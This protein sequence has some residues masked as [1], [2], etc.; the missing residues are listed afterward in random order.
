[1]PRTTRAR[2]CAAL[3]A[4]HGIDPDRVTFVGRR[5]RDGYLALLDRR[6]DV[7]LDTF[8]YNGHTTTAATARHFPARVLNETR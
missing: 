5:D 7:A 3:Y 8:P 4:R 2:R 1:M 6:C